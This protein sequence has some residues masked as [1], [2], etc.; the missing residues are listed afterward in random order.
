MAHQACVLR[1]DLEK[2]LHDNTSLFQKIGTCYKVLYL[3][4]DYEFYRRFVEIF[5][6]LMQCCIGREDKLNADNRL[7]V[8]NFKAELSKQ[9][10][11][12]C[13]TVAAS[14]SQQDEHLQ[15][16]QKLCHSFLDIH[17]KVL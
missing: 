10:G 7:V 17:D 13:K 3:D 16:V 6:H 2:A 11:S 9:I 8:H 14:T 5:D 12:L 4:I 15:C 1:S